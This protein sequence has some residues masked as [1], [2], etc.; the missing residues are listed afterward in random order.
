[1]Y[2]RVYKSHPEG[3]QRVTQ[4]DEFIVAYPMQLAG[5]SDV[6]LQAVWKVPEAISSGEYY[7]NL[8]VLSNSDTY[9][10]STPYTQLPSTTH[11]EFIVENES[12]AYPIP[13]FDTTTTGI[14]GAFYDTISASADPFLIYDFTNPTP[15]TAFRGETTFVTSV[16]NPTDEAITVPVVWKQYASHSFN[17]DLLRHTET[18]EITVPAQ[19]TV[20]VSFM[21]KE[22]TESRLFV[23]AE[24]SYQEY[25]NIISLGVNREGTDEYQVT[26]PT[27]YPFAVTS[28]ESTMLSVCVSTR[29]QIAPTDPMTLVMTAYDRSDEVIH[30]LVSPVLLTNNVQNFTDSFIATADHDFVKLTTVIMRD[31]EIMYSSN[32]IFES[33]AMRVVIVEDN[34]TQESVGLTPLHYIA[35]VVGTLVLILFTFLL[36]RLK[37]GH[38]SV[39]VTAGNSTGDNNAPTL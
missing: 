14:D 3:S 37:R 34:G 4:L 20:T 19:E 9:L 5:E 18:E 17:Q 22:Q 29:N 11:I 21:T 26:L 2:A 8:Y 30:Q 35:L 12:Q 24:F 1:V 36:Y 38:Q 27:I 6:P 31:N 23:T 15:P 10:V 28:G 16:N 25:K 7:I 13:Y 32:Q 33:A 39:V